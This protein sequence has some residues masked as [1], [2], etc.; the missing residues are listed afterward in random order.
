M[1]TQKMNIISNLFQHCEHELDVVS[2]IFCSSFYQDSS[3]SDSS[4]SDSE[5]EKKKKKDKK[6]KKKKKKKVDWKT[7]PDSS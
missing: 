2:A 3:S 6:K 7:D 4:S 1:N 5:D